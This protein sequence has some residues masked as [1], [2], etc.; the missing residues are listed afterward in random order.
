MRKKYVVFTIILIIIA[1]MTLC[2]FTACAS[3]PKDD[4]NGGWSWGPPIPG[5]PGDN[6]SA[7]YP[8]DSSDSTHEPGFDNYEIKENPV[9]DT[10]IQ[11]DL[12]FSVDTHTAAYTQLKNL[13]LNGRYYGSLANHVKIDQM[14]NYFHYD[15]STPQDDELLAVNASMFDC[16]YNGKKK[17]LRIGLTSKEVELTSAQN[18]IVLLLDVS[19]SMS[20]ASKIELMKKAMIMTVENLSPD[21]KI[22]IVTYSNVTK[23]IIDGM[24]MGENANEIKRKINDLR[25]DG[26]T[27][28]EGGIQKAYEVAKSHFIEDG[29]NRV[30]LATDGDFNIGISDPGELKEFISSKR[31]DGIYL[32]C[33]GLGY[34][35]DYSTATMEALAKSGNGY[36]GYMQNM[37]DAKKLLVDDLAS[38]IITIAKDVKAKIVFNA[39]TVKN[40]RLLG[41][42]NNVISSDDYEDNRTDAGEIGTGFTLSLCFEIQLNDDV[43]LSQELDIANVN[44]RY[45]DAK[46]TPEDISSE[47][48]LP[49]NSRC[50]TDEP[51][52]DDKF[53]A[54][55]VEFAL[56]LLESRYKADA[57]LDNVIA[58]LQSMEFDDEYKTQFAEVVNTYKENLNNNNLR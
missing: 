48:D 38:T 30:I 54:S 2:A 33:I 7:F 41:Y 11:N 14:L 56:I 5:T 49:I 16:P 35:Y 43:D 57:N 12:Y 8:G 4:N 26:G 40:F 1:S 18:N 45:K 13:I 19:G 24:T 51:S 22:S 50:Y 44:V 42:E 27:N 53:V 6:G 39:D 9:V 55:V 32:T 21:D 29:N 36:W 15:Y 34:N 20:G 46:S 17:L 47:L 31:D 28:G 10:N 3:G 52:Q 58:R 37:D 25:A 23:V